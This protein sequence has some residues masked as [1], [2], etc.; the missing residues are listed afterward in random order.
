MAKNEKLRTTSEAAEKMGLQLR[1]YPD[2][3]GGTEVAN[4]TW[5]CILHK[6]EIF[7]LY[8]IQDNWQ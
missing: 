8:S 6:Q 1:V 7:L 2:D 3:H 4:S 5:K